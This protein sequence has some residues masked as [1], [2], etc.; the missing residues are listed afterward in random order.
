MNSRSRR[1][2]RI[3][4]AAAVVALAATVAASVL[5]EECD[6]CEAATTVLL[7]GAVAQNCTLSV[8]TASGASS[9]PLT[10]A[11]AQ[12]VQ[13]GSAAQTC[14]KKIGYT[15]TV[16]SLN[17]ASGSA[18]AK[19]IDPASNEVLRYTAEFNNPTAGGSQA[20]VTNLL[21][22]ACTGQV[23]RDVSS[24][25]AFNESSSIFVNF[26]GDATLAAGTYQDTLTV[27]MTVK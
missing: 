17:C 2:L 7:Q 14:N 9:L 6:L 13:V 21:Q 4:G 3:L 5:I 10:T 12:H 19:V 26:S 15:L 8:S 23:A 20:T 25:K 11:G 16:T 18:G 22:S 1:G 24:W 27:T